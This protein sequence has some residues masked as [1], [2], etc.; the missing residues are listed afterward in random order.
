MLGVAAAASGEAMVS[1]RELR[2]AGRA[3]RWCR[4]VVC[5]SMWLCVGAAVAL[6]CPVMCVVVLPYC[7]GCVAPPEWVC[8]R[9]VEAMDSGTWVVTTEGRLSTS[10]NGDER[11][12][13]QNRGHGSVC[14]L[15]VR[16]KLGQRVAMKGF[17]LDFR[18][19]GAGEAMVWSAVWWHGHGNGAPRSWRPS[20]ACAVRVCAM[21]V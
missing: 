15:R 7:D 21:F 4:A 13:W 5:A 20:R 6:W 11:P 18:K 12:W 9:R 3:S 14:A 1:E 17:A 8:T 16:R 2:G 10:D 19:P